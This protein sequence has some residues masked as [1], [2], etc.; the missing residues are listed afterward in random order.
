MTGFCSRGTTC[1]L[2]HDFFVM[3]IRRISLALLLVFSFLGGSMSSVP[4]AARA[5]EGVVP[6]VAV[7]SE[8]FADEVVPPPQVSPAVATDLILNELFPN[9]VGDDTL[10]EFIEIRVLDAGEVSLA[11]WSIESGSG[12]QFALPNIVLSG[13][14]MHVFPHSVTLITLTNSGGTL[15]LKNPSGAVHQTLVYPTVKE[16]SVFA[17]RADGIYEVS[18]SP[19]PGAENVFS[20]PV[21]PATNEP[22]VVTPIIE[23]PV[24]LP[25]PEPV[26]TPATPE[27]LA[28]QSDIAPEITEVLPDPE[29]TDD[30]EWVELYNPGAVELRLSGW[31]IDDRDGGSAPHVFAADAVIPAGGYL[32]VL[33]SESGLSLNNDGDSVR[34]IDPLG[35]VRETVSYD[36]VVTGK[37][38]A[39]RDG[40]WSWETPTPGVGPSAATDSE[41]DVVNG[42]DAAT[43]VSI[44]ELSDLP[45]GTRVEISGVVSLAPGVLSKTIG[46]VQDRD[47]P[48]AVTVR[49]SSEALKLVKRGMIVRLS[50]VVGRA[51][52]GVRVSMSKNDDFQIAGL[53]TTFSYADSVEVSADVPATVSVA[54]TVTAVRKTSL[55]LEDVDGD[56]WRIVMN[57][58][59][60]ALPM[61]SKGANVE[62]RGVAHRQDEKMTL[63]LADV[64]DFRVVVSDT[65]DSPGDV[66]GAAAGI[67][68]SGG[69]LPG[70]RLPWLWM[71]APLVGGILLT[72]GFQT[73]R[74]RQKSESFT[75]I[76][77][78]Q[79]PLFSAQAIDNTPKASYDV[80]TT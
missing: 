65:A 16:G 68:S 63:Y 3:F 79:L 71:G 55:S 29:G 17:R 70:N 67:I 57:E 14:G 25:A 59:N 69:S 49:F 34:V 75:M 78:A 6:C 1:R 24:V 28:P 43:E 51:S 72:K 60:M 38:Y 45:D 50:G 23:E 10:G 74:Q 8:P 31:R 32:V 80:R 19:T 21:V 76:A 18:S 39:L 73:Y 35:V 54:G 77:P 36:G 4:T 37:S 22:V 53:A 2:S 58:K 12:K 9:P 62:V 40:D 11:G 42:G 64:E 61:V 15:L 5:E 7:V 48:S 33:R 52:S 66:G 27:A 13:S 46:V 20:L 30:A 26:T 47:E 56:V 41:E 44:A